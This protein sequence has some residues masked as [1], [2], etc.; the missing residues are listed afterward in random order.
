MLSRRLMD[1]AGEVVTEAKGWHME[2]NLGRTAA[3]SGWEVGPPCHQAAG[4]RGVLGGAKSLVSDAHDGRYQPAVPRPRC[5]AQEEK[6]THQVSLGEQSK[7]FL[8]RG[9]SFYELFDF[10]GGK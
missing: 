7:N 8:S 4:C 3:Y 9:E 6:T 2:Q 1:D 5:T 10:L